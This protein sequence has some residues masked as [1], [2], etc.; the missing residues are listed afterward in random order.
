VEEEEEEEEEEDA[1]SGAP[2]PITFG[3]SLILLLS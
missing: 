1:A 2:L 3:K